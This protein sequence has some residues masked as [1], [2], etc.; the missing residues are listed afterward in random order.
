MNTNI[1][2]SYIIKKKLN[3]K[4]YIKFIEYSNLLSIILYFTYKIKTSCL[5]Y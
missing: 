4:S 2:S 5:F 3:P 1:I